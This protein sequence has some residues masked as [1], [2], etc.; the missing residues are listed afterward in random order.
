MTASTRQR[1]LWALGGVLF[2]AFFIG[3]D[4]LGGALA[5]GP[6]PLPGAPVGEVVR[7]FTES[8][9]AALA[10]SLAQVLS[11]LSLLVFVAPVATLVRRAADDRGALPGLASGGGILSAGF[12]LVSA[13]LAL[14]LALAASGLSLGLVDVLRGANFLTGGTLHVASLGLFVGAASVAAR[15]TKA[16]P[17]WVC[18]LGLVQATLAVLSLASLIFFPAAL[19]I[20]LGRMLGFVWCI[21]VG[22]VLALGRQHRT[23]TGR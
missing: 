13:L 14:A 21:A 19:L 9:T 12:L 4:F 11:A 2:A 1:N 5:T 6:L 15:R 16:L 3:S 10:V 8:Q 17:R 23:G 7:Y 22:I 18:W 20:L